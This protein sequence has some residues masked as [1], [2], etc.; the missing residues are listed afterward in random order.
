MQ[1]CVC[2]LF[3][4]T[5]FCTPTFDTDWTFLPPVQGQWKTVITFGG[6]NEDFAHGVISTSDGG[7]AIVGNT[8]STDGD[9]SQKTRLGSD[10][11]LIK[12]DVN[13]K[14]EWIKTYGGT[15]DDRGYRG[16]ELSDGG[17]ALIGYSKS[18]DG[19]VSNNEGQHDNWLIRTNSKGE[20]LWEKSFG[21]L[22]HDHAYSIL[23]TSDGGLFFNGFL[24]VTASNGAGQDGKSS[25]LNQKHGVGEFWCHKVDAQ[26][27][28][29]W[30]RYFGGTNNDRSHDAIETSQGDFVLVGTSESQDVDISSPKG[31]YDFWVV[32]LNSKGKLLWEK[33]I[34]GSLYDSAEAIAENIEGDYVI[35]GQSYSNDGDVQKPLGSSDI[36]IATLSKEGN[37]KSIRSLGSLGFETALDLDIRPDGTMLIIGHQ[38]S[39]NLINNQIPLQND[40]VLF[41]TLPNGSEI[42]RYTL[43]GSGVDIAYQ[44]A[45]R[46]DGSTLVVGSTTSS[47]GDFKI[48]QGGTDGFVAIWH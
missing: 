45:L 13:A 25:R 36:L 26:G 40:A 39:Q 5:T 1:R 2:V 31:S 19:D 18:N 48:N 10:L 12:F 7:F 15:D 6:T 24:D 23:A 8:E 20:I 34:G 47:N 42:N 37:L 44:L 16:I 14:Q 17:F 28:L 41:Y 46:E 29:E 11:F 32:K 3:L 9:F 38:T 33:S 21:F 43:S 27:T 35:V 22:G 30:R 4:L